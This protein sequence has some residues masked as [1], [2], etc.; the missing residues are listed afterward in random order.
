MINR[1]KK[2]V[3]ALAYTFVILG[4]VSLTKVPMTNSKYIKASELNN[5]YFEYTTSIRKLSYT[6]GEEKENF[7][8][9]TT[10]I[11]NGPGTSE[12][13]FRVPRNYENG[14]SNLSS[15]TDTYRFEPQNGCTINSI[16]GATNSNNEIQYTGIERNE[17]TISMTCPTI[18]SS[19]GA[20]DNLLYVPVTLGQTLLTNAGIDIYERIGTDEDEFFYRSYG[21]EFTSTITSSASNSVTIENSSTTAFNEFIEWIVKYSHSSYAKGNKELIKNYITDRI[22]E[23]IQ[24]KKGS[25]YN[26]GS[27]PLYISE[28]YKTANDIPEIQGI[29]KVNNGSNTTFSID[30]NLIGYINTY[31]FVKNNTNNNDLRLYFSVPIEESN[32]N[33]INQIFDEYIDLYFGIESSDSNYEIFKDYINNSAYDILSNNRQMPGIVRESNGVIHIFDKSALLDAAK[34]FN[35]NT[36]VVLKTDASETQKQFEDGLDKA[37]VVNEM[38]NKDIIIKSYINDKLMYYYANKDYYTDVDYDN[39]DRYVIYKSHTSDDKFLLLKI[40]KDLDNENSMK[41]YLS[42]L[43]EAIAAAGA[44]GIFTFDYTKDEMYIS[45]DTTRYGNATDFGKVTK[46]VE[47]LNQ[48]LNSNYDAGPQPYDPVTR[49]TVRYYEYKYEMVSTNTIL[50][51]AENELDKNSVETI[52]EETTDEANISRNSMKIMDISDIDNYDE[53]IDEDENIEGSNNIQEQPISEDTAELTEMTKLNKNELKMNYSSTYK[54]P[55]NISKIEDINSSNQQE[56]IPN[57]NEISESK[58]SEVIVTSVAEESQD[59]IEDTESEKV[60]EDATITED[61]ISEVLS[62]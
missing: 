21:Q 49:G 33:R 15:L 1:K 23:D 52:Q 43:D 12:I 31:N 29:T 41:V 50:E 19:S 14:L 20:E 61:S 17:I 48:A 16:N 11:G 47:K 39:V 36:F 54:L 7:P 57:V 10:P 18:T 8:S 9:G 35:D 42:D 22:V 38:N 34:V 51:E 3:K 4:A 5:E 59:K 62:E 24:T 32:K 45:I 58:S 44:D 60:I 46:A 26:P 6:N 27:I 53:K 25:S 2:G 56:E 28:L 37:I 55:E 13:V 40:T 30:S